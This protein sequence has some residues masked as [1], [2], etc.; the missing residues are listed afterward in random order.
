MIA[1]FHREA[2]GVWHNEDGDTGLFASPSDVRGG[3]MSAPRV[4]NQAS[5]E[6]AAKHRDRILEVAAK[7]FRE[8]GFDG[9][10]VAHLMQ[11]AGFTHGGFYGHFASKEELMAPA[12]ARSFADKLSL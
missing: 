4:F 7:L 5:R 3:D 12:C 6:Q 2:A 10:G 11:Q 8:H 9:I 1:Q